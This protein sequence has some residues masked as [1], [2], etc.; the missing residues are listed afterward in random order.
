MAGLEQASYCPL[1]AQN[2][3]TMV[4]KT[5]T[6][7]IQEHHSTVKKSSELPRILKPIQCDIRLILTAS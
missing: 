4:A 2:W 3:I 7:P 5:E 6:M 1:E